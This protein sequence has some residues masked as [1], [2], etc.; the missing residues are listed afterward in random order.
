MRLFVITPSKDVEDETT[1]VTKMF[2][3]GLQTLHLRKPRHST[4]R[5]AEYL[6][7]IPDHFHNR[8]V[9][10][11]H[12]KLALR[13]NL[14]GIHLS[15]AHLNTSWRYWFIR[16]RLRL[17]F[18]KVSIS[19][20]YSRLQ[21]AYTTEK[22]HFDYYMIG[23]VFNNMTGDLYSGFY[24]DGV[25]AANKNCGKKLVARGGTSPQSILKAVNYGFYGI[26]FNS[27]IW[28]ADHPFERFS[29]VLKEFRRLNLELL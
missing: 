12:H 17:K 28:D 26:A 19:R 29:E 21:Q 13:F 23:T 22:Q 14:K 27:Y 1:L 10:H 4:H 25:V 5:M 8:I 7:A 18:S 3:S 6:K 20:S 2:E 24:E 11:S 9:V 15:R 16:T